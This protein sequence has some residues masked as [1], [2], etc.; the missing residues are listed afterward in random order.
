MLSERYGGLCA[1]EV[2]LKDYDGLCEW[3]EL[4]GVKLRELE[5]VQGQRG[6]S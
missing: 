6:A 5:V 1:G 4:G 3:G 2:H